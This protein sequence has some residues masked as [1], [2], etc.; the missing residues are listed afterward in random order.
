MT[1]RF[2]LTSCIVL[3]ILQLY[4]KE[5]AL[6]DFKSELAVMELELQVKSI[7]PILFFIPVNLPYA[8]IIYAALLFE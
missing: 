6:V 5:E 2:T 3:L 8:F 4:I 7:A 1:K